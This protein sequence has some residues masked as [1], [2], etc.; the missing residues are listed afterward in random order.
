MPKIEIIKEA[1][2]PV[3]Y[4]KLKVVVEPLPEK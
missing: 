1:S 4:D 3:L 2:L